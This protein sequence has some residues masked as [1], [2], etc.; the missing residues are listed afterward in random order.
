[1]RIAA[2]VLGVVGVLA[3]GTGPLRAGIKVDAMPEGCNRTVR[4]SDGLGTTGTTLGRKGDKHLTK[5]YGASGLVRKMTYDAEGQ[6]VRSD[7]SDGQWEEFSPHECFG[8]EGKCS[9]RFRTSSG[10]DVV[11]DRF[12]MKRGSAFATPSALPGQKAY[13][14]E[15]YEIGTYG[16]LAQ[17]TAD[18]EA[19]L[20]VRI[21][22]CE[23]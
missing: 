8:L 21:S 7:W 5:V 1:M 15:L 12:T 4:Y 9:F 3:G 19:S 2:T 20:L 10:R 16:I 23:A 6:V 13:R 14:M 22:D 11:I 17:Y 18:G